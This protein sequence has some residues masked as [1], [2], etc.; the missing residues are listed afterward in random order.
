M[1][2]FICKVDLTPKEYLQYSEPL[3]GILKEAV[4][5]SENLVLS[6]C[7]WISHCR[8][9]RVSW[10]RSMFPCS[11]WHQRTCVRRLQEVL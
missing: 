3:D 7:R 1:T 10:R 11:P 4:E 2:R 5:L 8:I 9:I 6:S